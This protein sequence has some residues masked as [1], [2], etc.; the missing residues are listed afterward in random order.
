MKLR[1]TLRMTHPT[2]MHSAS[3]HGMVGDLVK[4]KIN[5]RVLRSSMMVTSSNNS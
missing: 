5:A 3:S 4:L 2:K 1:F